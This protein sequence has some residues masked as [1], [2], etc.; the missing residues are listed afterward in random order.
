MPN[1]LAEPAVIFLRD[2]KSITIQVVDGCDLILKNE[3]SQDALSV[4][5]T[6]GTGNIELYRGKSSHNV[7]IKSVLGNVTVGEGSAFVSAGLVGIHTKAGNISVFLRCCGITLRSMSGH[8]RGDIFCF[9][10]TNQLHPTAKIKSKTKSG[11]VEMKV[12]A[13]QSPQFDN[14]HKSM[15]GDITLKYGLLHAAGWTLE[16]ITGDIWVNGMKKWSSS[17][18][19]S[20]LGLIR[21]Q[22][23]TGDITSEVMCT[24][25]ATTKTECNQG[26]AHGNIVDGTLE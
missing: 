1:N 6:S 18:Q 16:A 3:A 13:I 22:T 5:V 23:M 15:S 14:N 9:S 17:Y 10:S 7:E 4:I 8:I 12:L 21:V 24:R 20:G 19:E 25:G 2:E 11:S 26:Q